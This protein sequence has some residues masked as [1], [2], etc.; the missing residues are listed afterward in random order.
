MSTSLTESS[1]RSTLFHMAY[2]MLAGTVAMNA[3]NFVDT[4]FV[5]KLGTLPLAAMGLTFPV[6]MLLTFIA[7]GIGTGITA[8]TSHAIGRKD[9]G[10]ASRIVTHG[11]LLV[12]SCSLVLSVAGYLSMGAVFRRIG[13]DPQTLPLVRSYMRIWYFGA[14]FM[15]V[16]A[17]ATVLAQAASACW[18]LHLLAAKDHLLALRTPRLSLFFGS[19]RRIMGFAVPGSLSMVLM[20]ISSTVIT[21]LVSTH[22]NTALAAVSAAGRMEMLAF[23]IPMA[24][25]MSLMPFVG[26]NHGAGHLNRIRAAKTTRH[27]VRADHLVRVRYDGSA[28]V[29]QLHPYRCSQALP[30]DRAECVQSSCA[31]AA[32]VACRQPR[33]RCP[34]T[35]LWPRNKLGSA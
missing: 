20:P 14:V 11:I 9:R 35:V 19:C 18:L 21:A 22:G 7:G 33:R 16:P 12:T 27:A 23:V 30:R 4:W 25:G 15:A 28:S 8:L 6:I 17:L 24:L 10:S 13:A 32:A 5:S 1:V 34:R 26:Q 2:P 3:Y 29:L 31:S